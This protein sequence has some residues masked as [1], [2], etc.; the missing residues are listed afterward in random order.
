MSASA[1]TVAR[2]SRRAY[3]RRL[4]QSRQETSRRLDRMQDRSCEC[5]ARR[6]RGDTK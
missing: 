4:F 6:A 2:G 5:D 1:G 3:R